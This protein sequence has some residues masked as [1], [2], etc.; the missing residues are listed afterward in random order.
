MQKSRRDVIT[1][2]FYSEAVELVLTLEGVAYDDPEGVIEPDVTRIHSEVKARIKD[3][4]KD[5]FAG[6]VLGFAFQ[7]R[8]EGYNVQFDPALGFMLAIEGAVTL[9]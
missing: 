9:E 2:E 4:E 8:E 7:A 5:N 1:E 6:E 3:T